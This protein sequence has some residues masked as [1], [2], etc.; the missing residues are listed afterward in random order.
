MLSARRESSPLK[1]NYTPPD[2]Q[3]PSFAS[4][5]MQSFASKASDMDAGETG[6]SMMS[7]DLTGTGRM[8]DIDFDAAS[9]ASSASESKSPSNV[10]LAMTV[11]RVQVI[12]PPEESECTSNSNFRGRKDRIVM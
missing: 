7:V 8:C 10:E 6:E 1:R 11:P 4:S 3:I 9:D 12:P 5:Q 2:S